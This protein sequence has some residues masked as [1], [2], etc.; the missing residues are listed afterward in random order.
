MTLETL[1]LVILIIIFIVLVCMVVRQQT[2]P[3][4][5]SA[6]CGCTNL[7]EHFVNCKNTPPPLQGRFPQIPLFN[8]IKPVKNLP[9]GANETMV[10]Y[11]PLAGY[12]GFQG[13]C[14]NNINGVNKLKK[15]NRYG[16]MRNS[17]VPGNQSYAYCEYGVDNPFDKKK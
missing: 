3:R 8:G 5:G 14:Y 7:N 17:K 10:V 11:D 6:R 1:I 15:K 4:S 13:S 9:L 12:D 2:A 16:T